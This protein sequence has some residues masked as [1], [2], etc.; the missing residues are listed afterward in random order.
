MEPDKTPDNNLQSEIGVQTGNVSQKNQQDNNSDDVQNIQSEFEAPIIM[1]NN[2]QNSTIIPQRKQE[3]ESQILQTENEPQKELTPADEIEIPTVRTYK[4]DVNSTVSRDK[5]TTAKVLIAEQKNREKENAVSDNTSIQNPK[6]QFK[7]ILSLVLIALAVIAI[8]YGTFTFLIPKSAPQNNFVFE[9]DQSLII[10]D[11]RQTLNVASVP[12][13]EF[14]LNIN[15]FINSPTSR[16]ELVE[17]IPY[18]EESI[19]DQKVN[20]KMSLS[21]F[22]LGLNIQLPDTLLRSLSNDYVF[23]K[24]SDDPFLLVRVS[25]FGNT[26]NLM[27][28]YENDLIRDFS[29][30]FNGFDEYSEL[31]NLLEL[32]IEQQASEL[33]NEAEISTEEG[34]TEDTGN[35]EQED[36]PEVDE[37]NIEENS[38][39]TIQDQIQELRNKI[40]S[41]ENFVDVVLENS[42]SRVVFDENRD[43]SIFYTLIDREWL[44]ITRDT[45]VLKE[46][47]RRIREKALT[48]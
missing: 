21:N 26:Y 11:Q 41:Y 38:G 31:Q 37:K 28:Q 8:L 7:V 15:D 20:R 39:P 43:I 2:N 23:G 35:E 48:E 34:V 5:I 22:L 47:K 12:Q 19:E 1:P 30:I 29:V 40:S 17:F 24:Y 32:N 45:S 46:I 36:L 16:N 33:S 18:R 6:N 14:S 25:D 10:V 4:G 44:L 13:N 27:F 9:R 42:D 3:V